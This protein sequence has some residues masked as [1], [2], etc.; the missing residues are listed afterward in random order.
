[1]RDQILITYGARHAITVVLTTLA[2]P[3]LVRPGWTS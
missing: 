1:V 2:T 3:G